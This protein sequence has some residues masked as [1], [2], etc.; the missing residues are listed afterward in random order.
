MADPTGGRQECMQ[1]ELMNQVLDMTVTEE[2]I[3]MRAGRHTNHFIDGPSG[4]RVANA[5]FWHTA[6]EGDFVL[7]CRV[8]VDFQSTY[9]NGCLFIHDTDERWIKFAFEKNEYGYTSAVAVVTDGISDD[10][11]GERVDG[12]S[13][14]LQILRK[15]DDWALHYALDGYDW[16]MVR[17]FRLRMPE[18]VRVGISLQSPTGD[19]VTGRFSLLTITENPYTNLRALS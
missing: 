19:S 15:G 17:Y 14:W 9:D 7:R 3:F 4:F 2:E 10:C 16:R 6:Q 8:S 13:V 5:P 1:F 12:E 18:T 11:N